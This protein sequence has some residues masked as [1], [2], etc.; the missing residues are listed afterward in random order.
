MLQTDAR[1]ERGRKIGDPFSAHKRSEMIIG[2]QMLQCVDDK[3][4]T[5]A[6]QRG[7]SDKGLATFRLA[8]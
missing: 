6:R 2:K 4:E 1:R 7:P 8:L 5:R 3:H